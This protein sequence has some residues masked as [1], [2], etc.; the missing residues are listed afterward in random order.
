VREYRYV[1]DS[2]GR[3]FHDGSEIIDPPTLRFFLRAMQRT[4]DGR[5]LAICQGEKNWFEARD[6]PFVVQR[7]VCDERDGQLTDIDLEF[8]GG[9]REA[10]DPTTLHV[11][12]GYLYCLTRHA[13]FRARFGR[14]ALQ[15]LAAHL[16]EGENGW[17]LVVGGERNPIRES[18][19]QAG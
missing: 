3:I 6:T 13:T 17:A 14:A 9:L 10:L 15:S 8:A 1:V 19:P 4:P 11:E 12:N 7:L 16:V 18:R 5:Y 2:D